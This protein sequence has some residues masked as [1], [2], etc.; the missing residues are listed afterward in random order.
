MADI[1][2]D[3]ASEI[4][5]ES[6]SLR[7]SVRKDNGQWRI[8]QKPTGRQWRGPAGRLCSMTLWPNDGRP[9]S[10]FDVDFVRQ[11]VGGHF[12]SVEADGRTVRAVYARPKSYNIGQTDFRIAFTLS[13]VGED[14][15]E[16]AYRVLEDDPR[17]EIRSV[18]IIDDALAITDP[19]DYAVLPVFQG[20]MVP[21]GSLFS[22]LPKDWS[23]C[24]KT[25]DVV[26]T[27]PGIGRWNMMMFGLVGG[28]STLVCTWDDP[29]IEPGVVGR[30]TGAERAPQIMHVIDS[31]AGAAARPAET[32]REIAAT[33]VLNRQAR[34]VR[35][36]FMAKA[37]YVAVAKYYREVARARGNF[38]TLRE[39]MASSP[40]VE[41]N[42]GALRLSVAPMWGRSEGAGWS[43]S[44]K[45]GE[46]RCDYTFEEVAD[47]AEHLKNDLGIDRAVCL[48]KAWSRRGYDM[49]YPD[50]FPAAEPCGGNEGLA[51]AS[52]RVQALGWLFGLHDNSL[53]QFE[54]CPSTDPGHALVRQDGTRVQGGIGIPRWRVQICSPAHMMKTAERNYPQYRDLFSLNF[55][56]TDQIAALPVLESFDEKYPVT[57]RRC[58]E[59]YRELVA[60]KR[61]LVHTIASEIMDEWAVPMFDSLGS[62]MG[63]IHDYAWPIPLFEL[64]YGDCVNL[65]GWSWGDLTQAYAINA[66][67]YGRIPYLPFPQRNYLRDGI[68]MDAQGY[69]YEL[70][71]KKGYHPDNIFLRGDRGWGEDLNWYDRLVKNV[72][73]VASPLN[74]LTAVEEMTGH[75]FLASDRLVEKITFA[76]D[77]SIVSNRSDED[78]EHEGTLLPPSGFL[79][80]GPTF[81]A[82]YAK[83]HGGVAYPDGA[84]FTVRSLDGKPIEES[85]RVRVYH[86]FGGPEVQVG[87]RLFRV[88]REEV[89][90]PGSKGQ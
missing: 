9:V 59:I 8:L 41:K 46:T 7:L 15:V 37:G 42:P 3:K 53:L 85:R 30:E 63:R 71:W 73:E 47:V 48:V 61:S 75:A 34:S 17:W 65:E 54:E 67:A 36:H 57:R 88:A 84:L 56:Y 86:G 28:D 19:G 87:G 39:K 31:R 51:E 40:E 82:F 23:I 5:V 55:M 72:Y 20:E 68:D 79:A 6:A 76:N 35:L 81:I 90:D 49:D 16:L 32:G 44:V 14:D 12:E 13:L 18:T 24:V 89:V 52:R 70:W 45:P 62:T 22:W 80:A 29:D 21:V 77:L 11:P 66:I 26:G 4:S 25:S 74:E 60:Y 2:I 58:I 38:F 43:M 33:V 27:Y 69:S 83:R 78:F 1:V 50:L 10:G 64:V